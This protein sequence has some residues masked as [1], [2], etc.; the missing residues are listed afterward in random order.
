MKSLNLGLVATV[1]FFTGLLTVGA[2]D[3]SDTSVPPRGGHGRIKILT[4]PEK[5]QAYMGGVNLGLTPVDAEFESGRHTLTVMLDGEEIIHQRVNI[6][7]DS[8]TTIDRTL[9]IP[10][11]NLVIRPNQLGTNYQVFVDSQLVGEPSNNGIMTLRRLNVGLRTIRV[12]SGKHSGEYE[13][14]IRPEQS[15]D[16]E[17]DLNGK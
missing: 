8:T 5:A 6:W 11:G 2:Q 3:G 15:V 12:V 1:I 9:R 14:V 4:K 10:F 17:V 16:L 13:V 7:P